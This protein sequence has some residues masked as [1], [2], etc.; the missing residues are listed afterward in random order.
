MI[1]KRT[2]IFRCFR[3]ILALLIIILSL[4]PVS[5]LAISDPS[6]TFQMNQIDVYQHN[7]E[8]NDQ[9]YL[10][11]FTIIYA[12]N[13]TENITDAYLIRLINTT[14]LVEYGQVQPYNYYNKG[15]G[16]TNQQ[17]LASIYIPA[18]S[19]PTWGS[20]GYTMRFEGN[21]ALTW[22]DP[23]PIPLTTRSGGEIN[24]HT[25]ADSTAT[26]VILA[27]RLRELA[28]N[29]ESDW[30][31]FDFIEGSFL[32][33]EKLTAT[34]V[35]YFTNVIANLY[36]ICPAIMPSSISNPSAFAIREKGFSQSRSTTLE[37]RSLGPMVDPFFEQ[38]WFGLSPVLF[39]SIIGLI[40]IGIVGAVISVKAGNP[41]P[42]LF[43]VIPLG[44]G[45][46]YIS[47]G[48][49]IFWGI[50]AMIA[51][52]IFVFAFMLKRAG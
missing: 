20:T 45:L 4:W 49:I 33:G 38:R 9:L 13:P 28:H 37:D 24:W 17:W 26:K 47:L 18:A 6:G 10:I 11:E 35:D 29:L 48:T 52:I 3:V 40:I 7:L 22:T 23:P 1:C 44:I 43:A 46:A 34:G 8:A 30:A 39:K 5:A 19:A 51:A 15:Y 2:I 50:I 32:T 16:S 41:K 21:P 36:T 25:T 31:V 42:A 14:S 27:T 12:V